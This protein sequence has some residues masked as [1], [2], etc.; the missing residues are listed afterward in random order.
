MPFTSYR[1]VNGHQ[2]TQLVERMRI[3][4]P[5]SI[6]ESERTLAERDRILAE[7]KLAADQIVEDARRQAIDLL[8]ERS[9]LEQARYE[10][11]RI[12]EQG[13]S[14]A[15]YRIDEADRYTIGALRGLREELRALIHQVDSGLAMMEGQTGGR[16]VEPTRGP[17][18][19]GSG[20]VVA[21]T[22]VD[23]SDGDD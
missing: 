22:E 14:D 18:E 21:E 16:R 7:A 13:R 23:D 4:V 11:Q 5:S 6:R 12:V 10:S 2:M 20:E 1:A 17:A 3:T 8:N 9:L 15:Q 19:D